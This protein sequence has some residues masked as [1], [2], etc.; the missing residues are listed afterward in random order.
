MEGR[1]SVHSVQ[2]L[3]AGIGGVNCRTFSNTPV[4]L[5]SASDTSGMVSPSDQDLLTLS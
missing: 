4:K 1:R 2:V 3:A 5:Y